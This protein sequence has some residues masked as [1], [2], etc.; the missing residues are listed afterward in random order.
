[1]RGEDGEFEPVPPEEPP[2]IPANTERIRKPARA[3]T[4]ESDVKVPLAQ[5]LITAGI[6]A[7]GICGVCLLAGW[8]APVGKAG[9]GGLVIL[10]LDWL[11][12][13]GEL[14]RLMWAIEEFTSRDFDRDGHDGPP[15]PR[16]PAGRT[17]INPQREPPPATWAELDAWQQVEDIYFFSRTVWSRQAAGLA[18]GQKA[19]RGTALPSGFEL[20]DGIHATMMDTLN[21]AGVIRWKGKSWELAA[22][23]AAVRNRI[24]AEDWQIPLPH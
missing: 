7:A 3:P 19:L 13:R 5:S 1:V 22:P 4:I 17:V 14:R 10:T 9:L 24:T 18:N 6:S 21:R 2:E 8:T 15:P 20:T 11:N 12:G 16:Q 23:P